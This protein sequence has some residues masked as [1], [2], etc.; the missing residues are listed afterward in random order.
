MTSL[1]NNS[2]DIDARIAQASKAMGALRKYFRCKQ[3]HG[4]FMRKA[5]KNSVYF[6]QEV[7][8]QSS[9]STYIKSKNIA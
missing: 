9:G 6:T 4:R 3:N 5:W 2:I 7:F 8:E 1:L